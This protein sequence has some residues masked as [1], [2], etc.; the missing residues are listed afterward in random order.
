[1]LKVACINSLTYLLPAKR[2]G[3]SLYNFG[4][5]CLSAVCLSFESLDV[6]SLYSQFHTSGISRGNTDHFVYEGHR[7]KVKATGAKM[8]QNPYPRN[9][10][11]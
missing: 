9:V 10:N 7:V 4:P 11:L 2:R 6:E 1:M 5:V 3:I 8:V